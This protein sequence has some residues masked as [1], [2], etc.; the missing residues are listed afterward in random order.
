MDAAAA[1][2][3]D[4]YPNYNDDEALFALFLREHTILTQASADDA[5]DSDLDDDDLLLEPTAEGKT[6]VRKIS[7]FT[8]HLQRV[9]NRQPYFGVDGLVD[10]S[11][12]YIIEVPL[13]ELVAWDAVR[14]IE[15]AQRA[16][17]NAMR[18]H[19]LFCRVIDS[20]L[21]S[22]DDTSNT[23]GG[24]GGNNAAAAAV[25]RDSIDVLLEQR[26]AQ[27]E[28]RREEQAAAQAANGGLDDVN[29]PLGGGGLENDAAVV[30][31][32]NAAGGT[33][34]TEDLPPLLMRRYE[35]RILPLQRPGNFPPFDKQYRDSA[36]SPYRHNNTGAAGGKEQ[37]GESSTSDNAI[38]GVSLRQIRSRALGHLVTLRGMVVRSSD[39]K[40]ACVV[41]TYTCDACGCEIYQVVSTKREFLPQR[42]CPS[43]EC[44]RQT[45]GGDTLHLQTRGSK[46]VKFQELK[47]QELPSQVPMGHVPRSM[48]VHC[49]GELTRL[50]SPGD[51][52]T[53]DGVFLPQRVAESGYR[54]M[55]AGLVATTFLEAQSVLVHKKSYDESGNGHL[56]EEE[57]AKLDKQIDE[58]AHGDDP[59][60]T[61][62]SAI[63]PE[64]F[65]HEDIKRAL[66]LML[67]G[68]CTRKLPD[69]M[70]I[71]GD[72]NIC[73]MGDP[74]VA[75][76][77]LLK[78]V[79]SIAPRGVYT[80]GKGSSG[81]GLTAAITKDVT[82]GELA[83]EGGA[84]VLADRGICA[85]D[86]F[87]KMDESDRT[88]IHEVMEQQT[89]SVAK[90]GIVATLNA[91]AAVLAAANPLYGRYNRRK[92]LSENVNLPN[93]L[94]SRFDLMFLILDVADVDRDMALARHV[95]FV[96]Q[97]EGTDAKKSD[98]GADMIPMDEDED[99]DDFGENEQ[100]EENDQPAVSANVLREYITRA[101]R[102]QP[103]VPADV[104]PYI[105][106]AYVSLR[107]QGT[108]TGKQNK[109]GDQTVMT[110]RQLLSILRL[111]QALARLRFSDYV[112]REDVDEAIRLTHMSKSS[113][114]DHDDGGPGDQ[115]S[116][117]RKWG[118]EDVTSRIF[119]IIRDY[120]TSSRSQRIELKLVEAMVLRKGF[121]EQQLKQCLEEYQSLDIIQMNST[122]T[123]IDLLSGE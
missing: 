98:G 69:G 93:S 39:V 33:G 62:A 37:Q 55:K 67:V 111:S 102:H 60:G 68:G 74:G 83:L 25:A 10:G 57:R 104:A 43:E 118:G 16:A 23:A 117:K 108:P 91:R 85:I 4:S 11:R 27:Q 114:T 107:S 96:H 120:S 34:A 48:S 89:V 18:Y 75:K 5:A 82:T 77:Q 7:C 44:R 109:N 66:L 29:G 84:L 63:A 59:V 36:S 53:I 70:R 17:G 45:K 2:G 22:M 58:I 42:L 47:L 15:L 35:L 121:T 49:R 86:E 101:R 94:L 100:E 103:V 95:T 76:S 122:G 24:R 97:N 6:L 110:A 105:V 30:G 8:P 73:L 123:H 92:S 72:I 88:A 71:R 50:A 78:H 14:G 12:T 87:D 116:S 9:K 13:S 3:T 51:I 56:S 38:E 90:A 119:N 20:I 79:A 46:F 54:A 61:L 52:V 19:E 112:A 31:G 40:P 106:E 28:A 113:L 1:A 26:R 99:E 32:N 21:D 80:T 65:G 41:A 115:S 81:V 64:I